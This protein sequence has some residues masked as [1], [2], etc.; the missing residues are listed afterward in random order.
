MPNTTAPKFKVIMAGYGSW[1][2]AWEY[3]AP[4]IDV[5]GTASS[6][7]DGVR[8]AYEIGGYH[9]GSTAVHTLSTTGDSWGDNDAEHEEY[10]RNELKA[11]ADEDGE[12]YREN[13]WS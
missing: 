11:W 4:Y 12:I 2:A 8:I 3:G 9:D 5:Y 7:Y 10:V 1:F 13:G 6:N